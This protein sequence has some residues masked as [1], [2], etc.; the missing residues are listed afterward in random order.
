[1][2]VLAFRSSV[3][4]LLRRTWWSWPLQILTGLT[5]I[6]AL[7]A[8]WVRQFAAARLLAAAQVTLILVG[9]GAAQRPYLI[10]PDITLANAAAPEPTLVAILWALVIGA[11]TL[12]P[13][14]IWL[15]RLFKRR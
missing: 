10:P 8:L 7:A 11:L 1:L 5:A 14:L 4:A 6:A 12:F 15:Y 3:L 9:W 2:A 13:S